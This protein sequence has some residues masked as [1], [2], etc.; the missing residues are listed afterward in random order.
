MRRLKPMAKVSTPNPAQNSTFSP[1]RQVSRGPPSQD[2]Y[3]LF[4]YLLFQH[5]TLRKPGSQEDK[6]GIHYP[7]NS[8]RMSAKS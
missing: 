3:F 8:N 6:E 4:V 7:Y 1:G 2:T 5:L